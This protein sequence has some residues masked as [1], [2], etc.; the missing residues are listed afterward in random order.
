MLQNMRDKAQGWIS[1]VIIGFIVLTFA[2]FG[3]E[4]LVPNRNNPDVAEVNGQNISQQ[5]LMRAV[6]QQ[7]RLLMQRL[8]DNF[9]S[10]IFNDQA[11]QKAAL[12][13]LIQKA[14]LLQYANKVGM[15]ISSQSVDQ[16]IRSIPEFQVDGEFDAN[17][18]QQLVSSLGVTPL[19]FRQSL[20]DD[21]L[22][23]RIRASIAGSEF[24]TAY[25]VQKLYDIQQQTRDIAW[26]TLDAVKTQDAIRVADDEIETYYQNHQAVFMTQE[27]VSL[28]YIILDRVILEG[29]VSITESDIEARYQ[30]QIEDIKSQADDSVTA[31]IILLEPSSRRDDKET[32]ALA[33]ELKRRLSSGEEFATLASEYSEDAA[34]AAKGGDLGVVESGFL[35][36]AF[37]DTLASLEKEEVSDPVLI[38]FGVV[39]IK[40]TA[41]E[42]V[43]PSRADMRDELVQDLK[44]SAVDPLF[45]EQSRKLADISFEAADLQQPA[46]ELGLV[47]QS[48]ALFGRHGGEGIAEH[49]TIVD[50]AFSDDLLNL[51]AN[52]EPLDIGDGR[53]AV[54]RVKRH[55]KSEV[56][57]LSDVR[58][59]V[60]TKIKKEYADL[61]MNDKAD[62]ILAALES[63]K[64]T[65]DI[66]KEYVVDWQERSSVK[67]EDQDIPLPLLRDAFKLPHP[68]KVPNYGKTSL[69]D[70]DVIIVAVKNV[71]QKKEVVDAEELQNI[72]RILSRR[73]GEA[74]YS[75]YLQ[76]IKKNADIK[77]F[78]KDAES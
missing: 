35:G 25:K 18:F 7:R 49:R 28:D 30:S 4:S 40:R 45:V 29:Q 61:Q 17:R 2:I 76:D 11:L 9:G 14:V 1:K 10:S 69:P 54:I 16:M 65:V 66:A 24:A 46:E 34:S 68:D 37:D 21:M 44:E 32:L 78:V 58:D 27:Q 75:E 72:N 20:N 19:Q 60:V 5:S 63:G 15:S 62:T 55:K 6:E 26:L 67:R 42:Q 59:R 48:T 50:V 64:T 53:V 31:S 57:P 22:I 41:D 71:E 38:D 23:Y 39:L 74:I 12:E 47:I 13:E 3:L 52:S 43:T 56:E 51:K 77:R 70:G 36:E 8:G 73:S 33:S